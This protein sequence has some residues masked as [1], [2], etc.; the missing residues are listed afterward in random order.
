MEEH[1]SPDIH[2]EA[3]SVFIG[4]HPW[5][6]VSVSSPEYDTFATVFPSSKDYLRRLFRIILKKQ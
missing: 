6:L 5:F 4:V 2:R 3:L 1:R